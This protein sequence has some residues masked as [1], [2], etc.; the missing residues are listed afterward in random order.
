MQPVSGEI[1]E[2]I[3]KSVHTEGLSVTLNELRSKL[4]IPKSEFILEDIEHIQ[5]KLIELKLEITPSVAVGDANSERIL[6][7]KHRP[8][9][10]EEFVKTEIAN[11][12]SAD[13][14]FK[15][16]MLF[17]HKKAKASPNLPFQ[18]YKSEGVI[19]SFIKTI[20]AFFNTGGGVLY[21]GVEDNGDFI[22]LEPDCFILG[23]KTF[24]ADKWQ[25]AFRD[26]IATRFKEGN[27]VND[28]LDI[29]FINVGDL[30]VARVRVPK[31]KKLSFVIDKEKN[32]TLLFRR[33]GNK[34]NNVEIDEVEE[35]LAFRNTLI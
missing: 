6:R 7:S 8:R 20:A 10:D 22:G 35:F 23:C 29:V 16:S 27:S 34:T 9:Y 31:R 12:E 25:L 18:E 1:T 11:I 4:N 13:L 30:I 28:Y 15:S 33:Q 3:S 14:E 19:H 17:D 24:D 32:R 21:L 26:F 2:L 5:E